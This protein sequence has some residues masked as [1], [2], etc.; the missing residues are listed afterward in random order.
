MGHTSAE[1]LDKARQIDTAKAA[2]R[3]KLRFES[4]D[5]VL[6][7]V[8][9]LAEA[10][11]AGLLETFGNWTLGQ[12]IGHL[13]TWAEYAY[14]PIP[15]KPPLFVRLLMRTRKRQ[16][17]NEPM[18]AGIRIPG[19]SGGTLGTEPM[20]TNDAVARYVHV[21]ERLRLEAPTVPSPVW[22][23]LTQEEAIAGT[24]R[25]AELHLGFF[26]VR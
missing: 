20:P 16:F 26:D 14:T 1:K 22:G 12:A 18:P 3:R 8:H 5:D 15:F 24:L 19:L 25:H 11:H 4:I 9:R 6:G 13:A 7:E 2:R 21:L 10:E 23:L 17:L